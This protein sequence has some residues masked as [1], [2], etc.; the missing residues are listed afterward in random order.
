M[1]SSTLGSYKDCQ[2]QQ[3]VKLSD[4][5]LNEKYQKAIRPLT[6]SEREHLK[7]SISKYGV[8]VPIDLNSRFELVDGHHRVQLSNE[9]DEETIPATIHSFDEITDNEFIYA[10]NV[11]RR[12]L[13][14]FEKIKLSY[15]LVSFD[16][17][18]GDGRTR[19]L[20]AKEVGVS[21]ATCARG[22]NIIENGSADLNLKVTN[23]K[24]SINKAYGVVQ[25]TKKRERLVQEAKNLPKTAENFKLLLGDFRD[26]NIPD[27]SIDLIFTDPPYNKEAIPLYKDLGIFAVRVLKPGCSLVTYGGGYCLPQIIDFLRKSELTYNWFC[28]VKH[29]GQTTVMNYNHAIACGKLLLWFYKG[30]RLRDT[31]KYIGDFVKSNRPDKG[32]HEWA[33]S[34]V[35]AEHFIN[36]ATLENDIIL[37]PFCGSG[38]TGIAA[39]KLNRKFIGIEKDKGHFEGA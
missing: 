27:N 38:T 17:N 26:S 30:D 6:P 2:Q 15:E 36:H 22:I 29:A 7:H 19:E 11:S 23:G 37:D 35:E 16:T 14:D 20:V 32:L 24:I 39:L 13:N 4:I 3:T 1:N 8:K 21:P 25:Q 12:H 33:Q 28:Y 9:L 5:K 10:V 18:Y 34:P 31:G